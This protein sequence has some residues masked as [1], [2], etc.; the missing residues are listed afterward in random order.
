[1]YSVVPFRFPEPVLDEALFQ[2]RDLEEAKQYAVHNRAVVARVEGDRAVVWLGDEP[3]PYVRDNVTGR[4]MPACVLCEREMQRAVLSGDVPGIWW[5]MP[6]GTW[7][8]RFGRVQLL[9]WYD[10]IDE[11]CWG[12]VLTVTRDG[13]ITCQY[14]CRPEAQN[15]R[16]YIMHALDQ[17]RRR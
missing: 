16:W 6:D 17:W 10:Q 1:M 11:D 7:T 14:E 12:P 15:I 9:L 8:A 3:E 4:W 2:T 13:R 5:C